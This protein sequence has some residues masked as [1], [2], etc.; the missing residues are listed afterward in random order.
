LQQQEK[1]ARLRAFLWGLSRVQRQVLQLLAEGLD[2]PRI[3]QRR[4]TSINTITKQLSLL[5]EKWRI[6]FNQP[7]KSYVRDQLVA[8]FAGYLARNGTEAIINA[9]PP[10][11]TK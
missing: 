9:A 4:G 7:E 5:Y 8:E 3:A 2:N 11:K 1:D 6:F 10:G